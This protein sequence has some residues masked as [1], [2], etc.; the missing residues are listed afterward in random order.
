MRNESYF[1][2]VRP[3]CCC[4]GKC[5]H[6]LAS[7]WRWPRAFCSSLV[8]S[9]ARRILPDTVLGSSATNSTRRGYL[10]GAVLFL[11]CSC[12]P[13]CRAYRVCVC[14]CRRVCAVVVR[15]L[16]FFGQSRGG[17]VGGREHDEGFDHQPADALRVLH[18][19][20]RSLCTECVVRSVGVRHGLQDCN[21]A[22]C[23]AERRKRTEHCIVLDQNRLDLKGADAVAGGLEHVVGAAHIPEVPVLVPARSVVCQHLVWYV[24]GSL[25][26]V[27]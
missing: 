27:W 3:G 10:Y 17:S 19:H 21:S 24:C 18:A 20:H 15:Y 6:S 13:H 14:V 26:S 23:A 16:E 11:T 9:S 2:Y 8:R 1:P 22:A 7:V 12:C 25:G 5:V 4:L